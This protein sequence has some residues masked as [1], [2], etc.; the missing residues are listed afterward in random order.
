MSKEFARQKIQ[1]YL[2][3]TGGI[4]PIENAVVF[5]HCFDGIVIEEFTFK[6]LLCIA[7]DLKPEE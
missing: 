1:E 7:Y 3:K 4:L 2:A 5:S 6:F